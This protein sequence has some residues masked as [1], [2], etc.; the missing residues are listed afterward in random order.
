MKWN[1]T[2][3][4]LPEANHAYLVYDTHDNYVKILC[5]NNY[6]NCWDDED[7]DDYYCDIDRISHWMDL[8]NRPE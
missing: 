5:Y 2:S 6:D 4:V 8:P 7:A 1:K 3:D